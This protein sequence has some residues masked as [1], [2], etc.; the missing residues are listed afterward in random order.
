M[1]ALLL[2]LD[3]ARPANGNDCHNETNGIAF[4]FFCICDDYYV[5]LF[6]LISHL[7]LRQALQYP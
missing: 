7:Y 2:F 4:V 5:F 6:I 3:A 1:K